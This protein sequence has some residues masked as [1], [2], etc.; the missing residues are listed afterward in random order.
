MGAGFMGGCGMNQ[1][2]LLFG[3][4]MSALRKEQDNKAEYKP[5]RK[6]FDIAQG[7]ARYAIQR[8]RRNRRNLRITALIIL[9]VGIGVVVVLLAS[10]LSK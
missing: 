3:S 6:L 4:L 8:H 7:R 2:S 5:G 10:W 1:T 9:A